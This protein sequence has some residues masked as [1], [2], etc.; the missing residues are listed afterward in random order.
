MTSKTKG[1][2]STIAVFIA[3]A[4][5]YAA[6]L[7]D[8]ISP[9][10]SAHDVATAL[11]LESGVTQAT[12]RK[13]TL[14]GMGIRDFDF[15]SAPQNASF[16][17]VSG[18]FRTR[19]LLWRSIAAGIARGIPYGPLALRLNAFSALLGAITVALAFAL[20]R[21]TVLFINFHDSPVSS[22]GRKHSAFGAA[23]VAAAALGLSAPFWIA[24]TRAGSA[25]FDAF[26]L[27][28]MGWLLFASVI[29]QQP[30]NLF[31]FGVLWGISVF[32]TD[33]G[34]FTAILLILL[35][36]RAMMVGAMMNL[37]CWCNLL[38]G[39]ILGSVS[40]ITASAFLIEYGGTVLLPLREL[41]SAI[42]IG[43]SFAGGGIFGNAPVLVSLFFVV[44]PFLAACALAMWRDAERNATTAGVLIFLL[45]CT[46]AIALSKTPISPWGV[47]SMST[48]TVIPV[49]VS[50]LA[51]ATV[52]YLA[53]FGAIMAKGRLLPPPQPRKSRRSTNT[54]DN[55]SEASVGRVVFWFALAIAIGCGLFN[56]REIRD[57]QDRLIE[58]TAREFIARLGKHTWI[59]S[60]TPALDTMLRISAWEK[61][62]P[63][64]IVTRRT[65][66]T[67]SR[68]L[69]AAISRDEAFRQ[70]ENK[71]LLRDS[72][73]STNLDSFVSTW[74]SIDPNAGD[75]LIV[76]DPQLWVDGGQT[77]IPA[78]I[79]YRALG[80]G[81][82]P[83]WGAIA[84]D[85]IAL[86]KTLTAADAML[87]P[88]APRPLRS[89]RSEVRAYFCSIGEF[90]AS[91][92]GKEKDFPATRT[93][94]ILDL[95]EDLR[96]EHQPASRNEMFY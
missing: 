78:A 1:I 11:G 88:A 42:R 77:P 56:W 65:N 38:V 39:I 32:E 52:G 37:R 84:D 71:S 90:L 29:S 61:R 22:E 96:V 69:N 68:R 73:I 30:R 86:W 14:E 21:G 33:T 43:F 85:H 47:F 12:V 87:G 67:E 6:S 45:A 55:F 8:G 92:L 41:F 64:H 10:T 7:Y 19:H 15:N 75:H 89:A 35:A 49:A 59:S 24:A 91:Q 54:A 16:R 31:I 53:S 70:L 4:L 82:K 26:L 48:S 57:S 94:Q 36:I 58:T 20:C 28:Y 95:V 60:T 66:S 76:D 79:G 44:L 9:G 2:I 63:L 13:V 23:I 34:I 80:K 50:I 93:R 3:F 62:Q 40:Y 5:I 74:I 17:V 51:A 72:L 83:D 46:S 18:E 81:E 25:S 27:V